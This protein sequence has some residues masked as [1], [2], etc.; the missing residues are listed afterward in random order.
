ML[1]VIRE[2]GD[3]T[4]RK[5]GDTG[6]YLKVAE[7]GVVPSVKRAWVSRIVPTHEPLSLSIEG[8][9]K[10]KIDSAVGLATREIDTPALLDAFRATLTSIL[11]ASPKGERP[12]VVLVSSANPVEGKTT[13]VS[14]LAITMA[15]VNL[16]VL[17]ID[18]DL[19]KP[20][21]HSFFG[22]DNS[23]GLSDTLRGGGPLAIR[24]SRI[25]NLSILPSGPD[26]DPNLLYN[27]GVGDL[28]G[29]L[30]NQFDMI[31]ID[32]PPMLQMPDARII[33]RH[34]DGIV[35]VVR[36][37]KTTREAALLACR[38]FIEDG[39][40]L[41]G[42]VLNDWNPRQGSDVYSKYYSNY[43]HY[44]NKTRET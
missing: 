25:R 27:M 29:R 15:K 4:L 12:R 39:T 36:A 13:V 44:Y 43:R 37:Q 38:R 26:S 33:A 35:L 17:L 18:A 1:I 16:R 31:L 8:N 32:T 10:H 34:T 21:V 40:P 42:V 6:N 24:Q 5:P 3:R 28:L 2:R 9:G 11:Y 7:L 19:R 20:R 41:L 30:R 14:N 22:I 23:E